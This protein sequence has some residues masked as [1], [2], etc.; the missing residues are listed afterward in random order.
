MIVTL[1]DLVHTIRIF[2]QYSPLYKI[3][4]NTFIMHF[5]AC[6]IVAFLVGAY[7]LLI[8]SI[9]YLYIIKIGKFARCAI[10]IFEKK[11]DKNSAYISHRS[12]LE[13]Q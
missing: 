11:S 2:S 3:K 6:Y 12:R 8:T 10:F 4:L 7:V 1:E 5:G 13:K 9:S